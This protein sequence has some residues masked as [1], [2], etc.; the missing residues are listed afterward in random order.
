MTRTLRALVVGAFLMTVF[1]PCVVA[2]QQ[3]GLVFF[4]YDDNGRLS[5][6][7]KP[8][9]EVAIYQYDP[10]GNIQSISRTPTPSS[11]SSI[12]PTS[13][14]AGTL[15][16]IAGNGFGSAVKD[17]HVL[18]NGLSIEIVSASPTA[19]VVKV[20]EGA[21]SGL[22][23]V[24]TPTSAATSSG[25]FT[26]VLPS[27]GPVIAGFTPTVGTPGTAVTITG[28]NFETT[29]IN[30]RIDF[31]GFAATVT[32]ASASTLVAAVPAG[33]TSGHIKE[34]TPSGSATSAG[35]F[36][37]PP[38]PKTAADV[39]FTG[40]MAAGET[41]TLTINGAGKIGLLV[42]DGTT[43]Q[44][45]GILVSALPINST[46]K[47]LDP[48]GRVVA[49]DAQIFSTLGATLFIDAQRLSMT[50]V[51]EVVIAPGAVVAGNITC[52]VYDV[53]PDVTGTITPSGPPAM[54]ATTVPGQNA[55]LT[56][57]GAAG[58]RLSFFAT[59]PGNIVDIVV[60]KPDSTAL[61]ATGAIFDR[62][63]T[64]EFS[65]P[66]TGVY[67]ILL[68][69]NRERV[70]AIL[71]TLYAVPADV[72][73]TIAPGGPPVSLT[74]TA[75]GQNA[76]L[77]FS[78][79]AGQ[80]FSLLVRFSGAAPNQ[81]F[82]V[83]VEET[84]G[85][86]RIS[87]RSFIGEGFIDTFGL[88]GQN[89]GNFRI[90]LS[91]DDVL[92]GAFTATL[93]NVPPDATAGITPGGPPVTVTTTIPGQ[94]A[95][96]TFNGVAGQ[97]I[98]IQATG[99][100]GFVGQVVLLRPNNDGMEGGVLT[101]PDQTLFIDTQTLPVSGTYTISINPSGMSTGSKT[102]TVFNVVDLTGAVAVGG[103]PVT[104]E[105][106]TPGQNG[107]LT[108][109]A[110][111]QRVTIHVTNNTINCV[112]VALLG[113]DGSGFTGVFS[114]DGGASFDLET[115]DLFAGAYTIVIDPDGGSTGK[116]TITVTSP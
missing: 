109:T 68:N 94:N 65:L 110:T 100:G 59:Y 51:F 116:L 27:T 93:F 23:T 1:Q 53:P 57:N 79:A 103:P 90:A 3:G 8:T 87:P 63:F 83:S 15:V 106:N 9:G 67:T 34:V 6:M 105:L 44:R 64:D 58:Q 20:P 97:K 78:S 7:V 69:P 17:N 41:K 95:K 107:V 98:G 29:P 24:V 11:I 111:G 88:Q 82:T 66:A 71:C 2:E 73:S 14:T 22:I 75:P 76:R 16:S 38:P 92:T 84:G 31:N 35:D 62:N 40:R 13:G 42:F 32:S 28:I 74:T 43:D 113:P 47:L 55:S 102:F 52:T 108:F 70:G 46:L 36:F 25:P 39:A 19:I 91:P 45:I 26:V 61:L 54:I 86:L 60:V 10:A 104:V 101:D 30:N 112:T 21:G 80:R 5:S 96:L 12:S 99:A 89:T 49:S 37:V 81:P 33:A 56:F 48:L 85:Q 115:Q 72:T 18:L 114:C 4:F 50:G 77:T